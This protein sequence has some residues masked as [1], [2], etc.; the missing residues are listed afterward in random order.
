M[1]PCLHFCR[2]TPYWPPPPRMGNNNIYAIKLL[3]YSTWTLGPFWAFPSGHWTSIKAVSLIY[4]EPSEELPG[5]TRMGNMLHYWMYKINKDGTNMIVTNYQKQIYWY[6]VSTQLVL[7]EDV[8]TETL[9]TNRLD[10]MLRNQQRFS[11]DM[12]L[13]YMIITKKNWYVIR[14]EVRLWEHSPIL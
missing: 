13:I 1:I 6:V 12:K 4:T 11:D 3:I 8:H 2:A 5:T 10:L 14:S 9:N 7:D